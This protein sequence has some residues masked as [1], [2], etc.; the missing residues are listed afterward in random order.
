MF[1]VSQF[2][3]HYQIQKKTPQTSMAKLTQE[4]LKTNQAIGTPHPKITT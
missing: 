4:K 2:G 3:P 1:Q